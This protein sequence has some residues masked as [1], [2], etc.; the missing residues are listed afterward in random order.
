MVAGA[1]FAL[2]WLKICHSKLDFEKVLESL[3]LKMSKRRVNVDK[4]NVAVSP[5]G[6]KD[7]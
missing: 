7:D 5:I 6:R 3:L 4:H 1:K 2:I